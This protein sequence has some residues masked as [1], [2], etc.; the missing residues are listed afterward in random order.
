MIK[1]NTMMKEYH[2]AADMLDLGSHDRAVIIDKADI[3]IVRL[4]LGKEVPEQV[5]SMEQVAGETIKSMIDKF[6]EELALLKN[7]W[8]EFVGSGG[9]SSSSQHSVVA[10]GLIEYG[11]EGQA[12]N[13]YRLTCAKMGFE[14]G[15]TVVI[16]DEPD[17]L[18]KIIALDQTAKLRELNSVTG[19][20]KD[21]KLLVI[22]YPLFLNK[23]VKKHEIE[24]LKDWPSN[25]I[26][27]SEPLRSSVAAA[28][29]MLFF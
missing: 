3:L 6:P 2:E 16:K 13:A 7:P 26:I 18:F 12:T 22:D 10:S 28:H 8:E 29:C 25:M 15:N 9:Q 19:Q 4:L 1:A 27:G 5:K 20:F 21:K 24:L 14:I 17:R 11:S 23:Y